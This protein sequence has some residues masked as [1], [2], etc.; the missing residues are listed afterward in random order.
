MLINYQNIRQKLASSK[1]S[2]LSAAG[3]TLVEIL[4]VLALI[5]VIVGF[6]A[7]R[8]IGSAEKAKFRQAEIQVKNLKKTIELY[9]IE[10]N[11]YPD[12]LEDIADT[13]EDKKLPKDPWNKEYV[14]RLSDD[15]DMPYEL[16]S[17]GK[18]D[19]K[20]GIFTK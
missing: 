5:A 11:A 16:Y 2:K 12:S 18:N 20:I 19:K 17:N 9:W 6:A 14:Y 13:L 3:F 7:P 1:R 10:N 8:I 15:D 4:I